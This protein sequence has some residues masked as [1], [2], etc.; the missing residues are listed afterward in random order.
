MSLGLGGVGHKC[1]RQVHLPIRRELILSH[2]LG[3]GKRSESGCWE[4][5][6]KGKAET[7]KGKWDGPWGSPPREGEPVKAL[8]MTKRPAPR[9]ARGLPL[10]TPMPAIPFP[11]APDAT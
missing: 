4:V 3:G 7:R 8:C 5:T 1:D 9:W 6:N 2:W 11:A 10:T